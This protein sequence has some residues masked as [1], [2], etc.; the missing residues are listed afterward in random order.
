MNAVQARNEALS[1]DQSGSEPVLLSW[2]PSVHVGVVGQ[3]VVRR[4]GVS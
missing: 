4:E 1:L 3:V 2:S